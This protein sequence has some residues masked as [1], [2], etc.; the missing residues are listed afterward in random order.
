MPRPRPCAPGRDPDDVDLAQP[1]VVLLGPVEAEH[2]CP[3][4]GDQQAGGVEPRL[5]HPA[6]QVVRI[7]RALLGVVRERGRVDR[8][9]VGGVGV[10][11]GPDRD[12]RRWLERGERQGG[13]A[14]HHPQVAH[15]L[16]AVAGGQPRRGG[17]VAVGPR[18][19]RAVVRRPLQEVGRDA[20]PPVVGMHRE[21][22]V[23]VVQQGE[24]VAV[25]G[26]RRGAVDERHQ[27]GLVEG[28]GPV[29]CRA[30]PGDLR[31]TSAVVSS[32]PAVRKPAG[33]RGAA[34]EV[35]DRSVVLEHV[36]SEDS[37]RPVLVCH[38]AAGPGARH[39]LTAGEAP[40][41]GSRHRGSPR[42]ST[43]ATRGTEAGP[44]FGQASTTECPCPT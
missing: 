36:A 14:T 44:E 42:N 6:G 2:P 18:R 20:L 26:D 9:H 35:G 34:R 13:V 11:V 5:G 33:R 41:R 12:T 1:G 22:E 31:L 17:V 25:D 43:R 32:T 29:R 30:G 38:G 37:L 15:A 8:H 7:H 21:G 23:A 27:R 4:L 10:A 19:Q 39:A 24:P 3:V 16:P 28:R 40:G